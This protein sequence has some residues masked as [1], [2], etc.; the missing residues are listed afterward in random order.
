M[1]AMTTTP[2]ISHLAQSIIL[3]AEKAVASQKSTRAVRQLLV[4]H[5][6][7]TTER[8]QRVRDLEVLIVMSCD[9]YSRA[10][11]DGNNR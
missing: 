6:V 8:E 4:A 10:G 7:E 1:P 3:L 11:G 2:K 5:F 9:S